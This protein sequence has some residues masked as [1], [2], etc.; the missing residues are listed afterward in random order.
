MKNVLQHNI[1]CAITS[2]VEVTLGM[3]PSRTKRRNPCVL[4]YLIHSKILFNHRCDTFLHHCR[5]TQQNYAN[6]YEIMM[7]SLNWNV[8]T[9]KTVLLLYQSHQ[10]ILHGQKD[11]F[12]FIIKGGNPLR[13]IEY[14]AVNDKTIL[15]A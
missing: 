7:N 8:L 11:F 10:D 3:T 2:Q 1:N 6:L 12:I 4:I 5:E 9:I 13:I 14:K 15:S